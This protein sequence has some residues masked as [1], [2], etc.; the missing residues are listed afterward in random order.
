MPPPPSASTM[1]AKRDFSTF[2]GRCSFASA[3]NTI[4]TR[5]CLV[6]IATS[7]QVRIA[8][9]ETRARSAGRAQAHR[10]S[11]VLEIVW[12]SDHPD[13]GPKPPARQ[14]TVNGTWAVASRGVRTT[15]WPQFNPAPASMTSLDATEGK[16][17]ISEG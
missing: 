2:V 7:L 4:A 13:I 14:R 5:G 12:L 11:A 6:V 17:Q 10:T 16:I 1:P 9:Y 15:P 8:I 3:G